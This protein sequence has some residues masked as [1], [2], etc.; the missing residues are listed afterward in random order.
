MKRVPPW[1]RQQGIALMMV[2]WVLSVLTIMAGGFALSTRRALDQSQSALT[3]S[4]AVALAD[5]GINYAMYMLTHPDP[6]QRWQ[7]D[8]RPYQVRFPTAEVRIRIYDE[9][10]RLDI[11]AVQE[12]TLRSFLSRALG[13][14]EAARRLTDT[15]LDWRDQDSLRRMQGAEI[16]EYRAAGK[17]P[18]PQNRPFASPE[19]LAGVLGLPPVLAT[20]LNQLVTI[21]SGQDGINPYKASEEVLRIVFAG[22]ENQIAQL[23]QLRLLP[24]GGPR[25]QI[26]LVPPPEFRFNQAQ[27]GAYRVL[28][29]VMN[30]TEA[31]SGVEAV[32]RRGG[33]RGGA[34]FSFVSFKP[35]LPAK[36]PEDPD[37]SAN[38]RRRLP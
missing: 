32:I 7:T 5:G 26:N 12:A 9:A 17:F 31:V 14:V 21:W 27:D 35:F 28:S 29:E 18:R 34:P 20:K 15:I 25:P 11:N 30:G 37:G 22:E 3:Q 19:E 16:E 2:L 23:L 8:G 13:D 10:G 1:R 36:P 38:R 4:Q 6:K 24:P 33:G